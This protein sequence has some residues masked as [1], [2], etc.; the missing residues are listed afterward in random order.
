MA[1]KGNRNNPKKRA[2]QK[3]KK[4]PKFSGGTVGEKFK[5]IPT[6]TGPFVTPDRDIRTDGQIFEPDVNLDPDRT[7]IGGFGYRDMLKILQAVPRYG[8]VAVGSYLLK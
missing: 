2:N 1:Y 7:P 8:G 4:D 6:R 3:V 5:P